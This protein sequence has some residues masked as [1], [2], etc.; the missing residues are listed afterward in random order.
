NTPQEGKPDKSHSPS[1]F[2]LDTT[3]FKKD[4][5]G[6]TSLHLPGSSQI[7]A[8]SPTSPTR[9]HRME[10]LKQGSPKSKAFE[11]L[12]V[13]IQQQKLERTGKPDVEMTRQFHVIR[14]VC[15][16][17][18]KGAGIVPAT[19]G[20]MGL[21][22]KKAYPSPT[23]SP[24]SCMKPNSKGAA[25]RNKAHST[26][27]SA[28]REAQRLVK[29]VLEPINASETQ[30]DNNKGHIKTQQTESLNLQNQSKQSSNHPAGKNPIRHCTK[31]SP[32]CEPSTLAPRNRKPFKYTSPCQASTH[33]SGSRAKSNTALPLSLKGKENE[34][35][36]EQ[37][38]R[39]KQNAQELHKY[40]YR[41]AL[42]RKRV[43]S[44]M[45][46][47]AELEEERK[48]KSVQ[49]VL[50]KQKEVLQRARKSF[51]EPERSRK[52]E[53]TS[54][55]ELLESEPTATSTTKTLGQP[56]CDAGTGQTET[57][58][59]SN[60]A[61]LNRSQISPAD[62][63]KHRVEAIRKMMASLDARVE[64]EAA[65]LL[66]IG[67]KGALLVSADKQKGATDRNK[68]RESNDGT[69]P[70]K[71]EFTIRT[72]QWSHPAAETCPLQTE[73]GA[74]QCTSEQS[75]YSESTDSTS[76]ELL[77]HSS[78]MS[79]NLL[80][81][82]KSTGRQWRICQSSCTV[83]GCEHNPHLWMSGPHTI[84]MESVSN[85]LCRHMHICGLLEVILQGSGSAPPVPP[86]TKAE[87][88]VLLRGCCPP[89]ASS[90]SPGVLACLQA[91]DTMLTDTAN[92]LATARINWSELSEMYSQS[93]LQR[94]LSLA[95]SQQFLREEE[96][97]ARQYSALF[98]LREKALWERTQAELAWLEHCK[99]QVTS[100]DY[101]LAE[102]IRKQEEVVSRLTQ[103]QAEIHHWRNMYKCGRQQR[104]LLL[105]H[106][107]D[108]LDIKRSATRFREVL[109]KQ[110]EAV[111]DTG[112]GDAGPA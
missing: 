32:D 88:A 5:S 1:T 65:Q 23:A 29:E 12:R 81:S 53:K 75:D 52:A 111:T 13:K 59:P 50:K 44:Q 94:H 106:Q 91:L 55:N 36:T 54:G 101:T 2:L 3:H 18:S 51:Q 95:Q 90:T 108:I 72:D 82:V 77:T 83:L 15:R 110:P 24:A 99:K 71:K 46:R 87:V 102:I 47:T 31:S 37:S 26:Y 64:N 97:R 20:V 49:E 58:E 38:T 45:K 30:K 28:W 107:R 62:T 11:S 86:C 89:M 67:H 42:E 104:R 16:V 85:R 6:P 9:V 80:S 103:E 40:M 8:L 105:C 25:L 68:E 39:H 34:G 69:A 19:A 56:Q 92:L 79:V 100:E 98:R 63:Q 48:R 70:E 61:D 84:L 41:R 74:V 27:I 78:H 109:E 112:P 10:L 43:E 76:K 35:P 96:L 17:T 4:A 60:P 66:I 22:V 21:C 93:Q 57:S 73:Q 33:L 14:K 7:R